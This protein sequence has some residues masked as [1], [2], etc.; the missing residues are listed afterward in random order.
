AFHYMLTR[1]ELFASVSSLSGAFLEDLA[2]GEGPLGDLLGEYEKNTEAYLRCGIYN[3]VAERVATGESLPPMLIH[4]G[5]EDF[6]LEENRKLASFLIAQNKAIRERL[7]PQVADEQDER[8]RSRKLDALMAEHRLDFL[9]V[10]S[11]GAHNW[12]FWRDAS[13][14]V[15]DFHWRSF[16]KAAAE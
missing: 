6:L 11:P 9:H 1:P 15:V 5:T 16:Q 8:Q 3:R 2:S 7:A 4:C 10:E 13:E 12:A 14:A